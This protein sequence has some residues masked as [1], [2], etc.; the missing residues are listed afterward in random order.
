VTLAEARHYLPGGTLLI[1]RVAARLGDIV[2]RHG[3]LV[4]INGRPIAR[5]RSADVMGRPLPRWIGCRRL[6]AALAFLLSTDP[7]SFDS[8]YF[9]PVDRRQI[10]G[11]ALPVWVRGSR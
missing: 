3:P 1:K 4:T 7:D 6:N 9:G 2:C 8:R 5:A 10:L 11:T